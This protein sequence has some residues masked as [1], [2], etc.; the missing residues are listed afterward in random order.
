MIRRSDEVAHLPDVAALHIAEDD[1]GLVIGDHAVDILGGVGPREIE[2]GGPGFKA[3]TGG[4]GMIGFN[5]KE[6]S[7]LGKGLDER[8]EF[9]RLGRCINACGM[10]EGGFGTQVDQVGP[11]GP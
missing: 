1:A 5:G 7:L 9:L 4:G 2:D 8:N 6:D 3:L 10:G 11:L